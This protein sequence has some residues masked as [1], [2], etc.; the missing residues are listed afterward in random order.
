MIGPDD[1]E[2]TST[3]D[4]KSEPSR[5]ARDPGSASSR[6][7][8]RVTIALERY[9]GEI[10]AGRTPDRNAFLAEHPDVAE[11]LADCL[12]GLDLVRSAADELGQT[13]PYESPFP[14][15]TVLGDFQILRE[16][17]RGGMGVV[18]EAEQRSLG[19]RVAL[20]VL[21]FAASLD[22]RQRQRFQV[23]AQAAALLHHTHIVPVYAV[24]SDRGVPFYAMQFI[25]GRSLA[26]IIDELPA[27]FLGPMAR[28]RPA[29]PTLPG[30]TLGSEICPSPHLP[31][32]PMPTVPSRPPHPVPPDVPRPGIDL[33]TAPFTIGSPSLD[34][35]RPRRWNMRMALVSSTGISSRGIFSLMAKVRS[36]SPTSAWP[37]FRTP[38]GRPEQETLSAPSAT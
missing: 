35:R 28:P 8:S 1:R 32:P 27:P 19:R 18:Y 31:P 9:L 24:G 26:A 12:D 11:E 17:G 7:D 4:Q 25:D 37:A 30:H 22:P 34:S 6:A 38:W 16:I 5:N 20:K 15:A 3:K 36:G 29:R 13:G 10:E 14:S 2:T 23:E 33:E 21:P